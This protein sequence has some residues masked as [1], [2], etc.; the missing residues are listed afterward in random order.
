MRQRPPPRFANGDPA[1]SA[2]GLTSFR[3]RTAGHHLHGG[4]QVTRETLER[5]NV[6]GTAITAVLTEAGSRA[7]VN[8]VRTAPL[9]YL[10]GTQQPGARQV[11]EH[12]QVS[13]THL[14]MH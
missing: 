5:R 9:P 12:M 11:S 7:P 2:G 14:S 4:Q 6:T 8:F 3:L 1:V 10:M 13:D